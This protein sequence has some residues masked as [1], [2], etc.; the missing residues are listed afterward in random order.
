MHGT[1]SQWEAPAAA[2]EGGTSVG[3]QHSISAY[4]RGDI[5]ATPA[6]DVPRPAAFG[7][8]G[9]F[10]ASRT[11]RGGSKRGLCGAPAWK[12]SGGAILEVSSPMHHLALRQMQ[13]ILRYTT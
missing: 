10:G 5:G 2:N 7:A 12:P 1:S 9:V 11:L 13:F 6:L 8:F 3:F 4:Q